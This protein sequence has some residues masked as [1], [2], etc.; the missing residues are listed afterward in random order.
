LASC[1]SEENAVNR[2]NWGKWLLALGVLPVAIACSEAPPPPETDLTQ[3]QETIA[4]SGD[5]VQIVATFLPMYWFTKAIA[6]D[7]ADVELLIPPGSDVHEYQTKPA[8]VRA[9]ANADLIVKNGLDLESFLDETIAN[10]GNAKLKQIEASRGIE[11]IDRL[12]PVVEPLEEHGEDHAH[13]EDKNG[14]DH[15][16]EAG[17]PHVWM[18]P[19]LAQQQTIAIRDGLIEIDPKNRSTYEANAAAYIEQLKQLDREFQ[20]ELKPYSN[21]S[22]IT[23][24]DAYPYLA[25][26]YNLQQIAVVEIPETSLSPGDIQTTIEAVEQYQAKALFGEPGVD[27]KL[28]ESLSQDLNLKLYS[29]DPLVSGDLD[30]QH[31]FKAMQSNLE[32]LKTACKPLS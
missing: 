5:R 8:D 16:H 20:E 21:C 17:N 26:R 31:Y 6:G 23:F 12:S 22:F 2:L 29:I 28:L 13:E 1:D 24:H 27:N 19:V 7:V 32:T 9:I 11:A 25:Q 30:P 3:S 4:S 10:S 15:S 18:D 14:H